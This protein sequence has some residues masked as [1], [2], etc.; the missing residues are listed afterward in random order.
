[1]LVGLYRRGAKKD[2]SN[3]EVGFSGKHIVSL[4][5]QVPRP[6]GKGPTISM[7]VATM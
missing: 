4:D 5:L 1:L 2:L 6:D 3:V 7:P